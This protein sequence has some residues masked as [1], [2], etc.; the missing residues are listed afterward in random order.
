MVVVEL[1]QDV[2]P[3]PDRGATER[4]VGELADG[5]GLKEVGRC[6]RLGG[7]LEEPAERRVE[8]EADRLLVDDRC[9]DLAPRSGAWARVLRVAQDVDGVARRPA[10]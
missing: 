4:V 1:G 3:G 7:E 6:D 5:D 8:L 2:R 10:P 9:R